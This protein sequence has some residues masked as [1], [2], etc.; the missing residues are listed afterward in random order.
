MPSQ[1]EDAVNEEFVKRVGQYLA[2]MDVAG[3]DDMTD[4]FNRFMDDYESTIDNLPEPSP[5]E[6]DEDV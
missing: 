2:D 4:I 5:K 3:E 1:W 6:D